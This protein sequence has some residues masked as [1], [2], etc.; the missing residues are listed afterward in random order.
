M[1]ELQWSD[2]WYI[3][4][5]FILM[6]IVKPIAECIKKINEIVFLF[7]RLKPTVTKRF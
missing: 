3:K 7:E 4:S 2:V 1:S 5:P 6:Y